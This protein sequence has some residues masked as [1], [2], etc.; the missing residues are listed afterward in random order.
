MGY[1]RLK[2]ASRFF[3]ISQARN[4]ILKAITASTGGTGITNTSVAARISVTECA[5]VKPVI[6][7]R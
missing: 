6:V 7:N 1:L 4:T 3:A 2:L 5:I